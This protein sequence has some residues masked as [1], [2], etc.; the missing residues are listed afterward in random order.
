MR[1][2]ARCVATALAGTLL[3]AVA[4]GFVAPRNVEAC[5]GFFAREAGRKPSLAYEQVLLIHD[6][7]AEKEHLIREV[8]F[9]GGAQPFGFVVPTPTRPEVAKVEK[10]PFASLRTSFPFRLEASE[11]VGR[12]FGN[13]HGRLGGGVT[14]LD[15]SKV[16]SFTAFVLAADDEKGLARWLA[17]N[18]LASTPE[19]DEWLA[20]YV[21]MKFYF[22]AMRYD[23]PATARASDASVAPPAPLQAETI[24]ISFA[25]PIPYYPYFE[26]RPAHLAPGDAAPARLLEMWTVTP[27]RVTPIALRTAGSESV[28]VRPLQDGPPAVVPG[29]VTHE[30]LDSVLAQEL[31]ALLPPGPLVVQTFQD[32]KDSREGYGDILFASATSGGMDASK[33]AKARPLL[34]ALDPA[35]VPGSAGK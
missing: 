8:A 4:A 7:V 5:G 16:G 9:R 3:F 22:V 14:V 29:S 28:W 13:G 30:V 24:W 2:R 27:A 23:P 20:H 15:V 34:G 26:P 35:L 1:A 17:D 19:A 32:Q 21:R 12:G 18:G 10:S 6:A 25:T 31:R 33:V 11:G